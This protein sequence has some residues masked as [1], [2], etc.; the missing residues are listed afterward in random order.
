MERF[1][2]F[3]YRYLRFIQAKDDSTATP[4]D[5]YMALSYAV[6]SQMVEKWIE[7]QK[8]YHSDNPRR[9]Y[10]LS[11]EYV[12]GK[13]LK[14]NII[15]LGLE[16][17]ASEAAENLGFSLDELY[18]Q[19]D[20]FDLG[21][22]G[23]GGRSACFLEALSSCEIPSMG[24]GLNYDYALFQQE[25][26]NGQQTEHP[27]DWINKYHSWHIRR[28][29][30]SHIINLFGKIKSVKG[31][32]GKKKKSWVPSESVIAVP[33]DFPVAGYKNNVVNTLR[34]WT[35]QA[36]EE[37]LPDYNNHGD[38]IRACEEKFKSGRITNYLFPEEVVH[39]AT[40]MRIKQQYFFVSASLQ[41]IFRRHKLIDS[42]ILDIDKKIIIQLS[43]CRCA[44]AIPEFM[45]LLIDR[46]NVS[47]DEAWRITRNVFAYTS[48]EVTNNNF[49]KLPIYLLEQ[50]IPR[51]AQ[52]IDEINQW[53]LD[54][55]KKKTK[56]D[57]DF[58]QT[59]SIIEEGEVKRVRMEPLAIIGSSCING[60][61]HAQT[62]ILKKQVYPQL[63]DV[64]TSKIENITNGISIR[65]WLLCANKP[66]SGFI[67][68]LI[69]D[70]W[71]KKYEDIGDLE[72][73]CND[74][75]VL[76][77]FE[78]VKHT[79]KRYLNTVLSNSFGTDINPGT[80]LDINC[81]RIHLCKRQLLHLFYI[82]S[83]YL[84]LKGGEDIG[85]PRTFI[86]SGR[87][88]PSDF[89][90]KQ[91]V[92]FIHI[93]MRI[94]NNDSIANNKMKI[95]FIPNFS[96]S[97]SEN[98]I[99]AA[100]L[101]EQ[102]SA[103]NSEACSTSNMKFA[104]NGAV[105]IAS[106]S[107]S[108]IEMTE[109][110]GSDNIIVFGHKGEELDSLTDYK[111]RDIIDSSEELQGIFSFLDEVLPTLPDG[112]LINPLLASLKDNDSF[113]VFLDF[114]DYVKKQKRVD[115]LYKDRRTWLSMSLK[116][117]ARTGWFSSDRAISDYSK[118]IWKI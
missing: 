78:D 20:D 33:Y 29:E 103:A 30:Y 107:G 112:N 76:S 15:N 12:F 63:F 64:V 118:E 61:S 65:R 14:Q 87:A 95:I 46:K 24:Y 16:K 108:N 8:Q 4:H 47:W 67:T 60:I 62:E 85:T 44:I 1:T 18:N 3:Y 51:H 66:L 19:E 57:E 99:P 91:V 94:I 41:D 28:P 31:E 109:K 34:L 52:I 37:F 80:F 106:Q 104:V 96:T 21:N 75:E 39:K 42:N 27:Y 6:R 50:V 40:E 26:K 86:F 90:A 82:L 79:A 73:F 11:M 56:D 98:V 113:Y 22:P 71:T 110:I 59:L 48:H 68:E 9:V 115:E 111:P 105:T 70:S 58:L 10:Y 54:T 13:S 43:G 25:I 53:H 77:R 55:V 84:C 38:Y 116:N 81:R 83:Q 7:T 89:L 74:N 114:S 72:S 88:A 102:I 23:K 5:K 117:I 17:S 92:H 35:A 36:S 2:N 93:V 45:R 101:S 32:N 97:L 100:D 69:G 49:E